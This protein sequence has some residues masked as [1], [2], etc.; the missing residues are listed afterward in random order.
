[1]KISKNIL[2]FDFVT[3]ALLIGLAFG[4]ILLTIFSPGYIIF[5]LLC[6]LAVGS[7][8]VLSALTIGIIDANKNRLQ[9]LVA[10][11]AFFYKC[12]S[13]QLYFRRSNI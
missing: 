12:W 2:V 13:D 7:W 8:Q 3:Q 10:V 11:F 1:M 9:Y 5:Y 4:I 6:Q